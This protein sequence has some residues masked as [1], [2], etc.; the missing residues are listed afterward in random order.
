MP[1]LRNNQSGVLVVTTATEVWGFVSEAKKLGDRRKAVDADPVDPVKQAELAQSLSAYEDRWSELD[2][3]LQFQLGIGKTVTAS[4]YIAAQRLRYEQ[5]GKVDD[6][7][8]P[9][10][11]LITPTANSTSWPK[12][13]PMAT[14]AGATVSSS[15]ALN[16]TD[17]NFTGHPGVSVPLGVD[18]K[19][20]PFGLQV[21]APRFHDGLAMGLA[22][23][24]ERAQPWPLVAP[25]YESFSVS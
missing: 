10:T 8:T 14:R 4:D 25:G 24:I 1:V 19:G 21:M 11:V 12:D 5:A 9:G 15:I 6:L 17:L 23:I 13:G 20:V 3:S 7:L 16:T 18:E 2:D 22:A